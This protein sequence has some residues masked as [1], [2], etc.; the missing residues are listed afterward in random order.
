MEYKERRSPRLPTYDYSNFGTYFLTICTHEKKCIFGDPVKSHP[1]KQ[2]VEDV[3]QYLIEHENHFKVLKYV[4]MPNHMHLLLAKKSDS[5]VSVS[6]FVRRLKS[7]TTRQLRNCQKNGEI[8]NLPEQIWQRS[9][10]DRV[11]R[12]EREFE[13]VWTYIENNPK[14]WELDCF[15]KG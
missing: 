1:A 3:V 7:F 4:V 13:M 14:K 9:F 15:Y 10:H 2:V 12:D 6:D 5:D 11:V 8:S